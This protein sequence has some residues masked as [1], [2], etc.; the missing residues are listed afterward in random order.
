LRSALE[1]WVFFLLRWERWRNF[2]H[3]DI[4]HL[5]HLAAINGDIRFFKRLGR[6]LGK[7]AKKGYEDL[8]VDKIQF[9]LV[10]WWLKGPNGELG[11]CWFTDEAVVEYFKLAF[12]RHTLTLDWVRKTR[13][14]LGLVKG[15]KPWFTT[16]TK[17]EKGIV[18]SFG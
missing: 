10:K 2:T 9:A 8:E 1:E 5:I 11:L 6:A 4:Q 13:Q 12:G 3:P 7:R 17:T 18:A 14:W 15:R 16:V